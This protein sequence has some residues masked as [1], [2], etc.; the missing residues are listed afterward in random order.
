VW[1]RTLHESIHW[2]KVLKDEAGTRREAPGHGLG[3]GLNT[4]SSATKQLNDGENSPEK[5][6]LEKMFKTI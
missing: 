6:G 4:I 1:A 3:V 5:L 2:K